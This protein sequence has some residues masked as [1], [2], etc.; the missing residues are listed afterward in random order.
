MISVGNDD[1][2]GG[3]GY[4]HDDGDDEGVRFCKCWRGSLIREN[5]MWGG[6]AETD[7]VRSR[8]FGRVERRGEEL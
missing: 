7:V 5:E 3:G 4:A 2:D 1:E 6:D 8:E